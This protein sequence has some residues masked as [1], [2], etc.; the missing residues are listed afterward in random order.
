MGNSGPARASNCPPSP[1][2]LPA[3]EVASENGSGD[4]RPHRQMS[5]ATDI[6]VAAGLIDHGHVVLLAT[7]E[8]LC[9]AGQRHASLVVGTKPT[10]R[11]ERPCKFDCAG[12]G[13]LAVSGPLEGRNRPPV[14]DVRTCRHGNQGSVGLDKTGH[15]TTSGVVTRAVG[16][17]MRTFSVHRPSSCSGATRR[18]SVHG[19]QSRRHTFPSD[20]ADHLADTL[21][22]H[23]EAEQ[24]TGC[25]ARFAPGH[26]HVAA[27][28]HLTE[29][30]RPPPPEATASVCPASERSSEHRVPVPAA[31]DHPAPGC[32]SRSRIFTRDPVLPRS[33]SSHVSLAAYR[34]Q[35]RHIHTLGWSPRCTMRSG[36]LTDPTSMASRRGLLGA[37]PAPGGFPLIRLERSGTVFSIGALRRSRRAARSADRR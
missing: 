1:P 17:Q 2:F 9:A 33:S 28:A 10:L 22:A 19:H 14:G 36:S 6:P 7:P 30:L 12:D 20:N 13:Q 24:W 3:L 35:G 21:L 32:R 11:L 15:V 5:Q 26:V 25:G 29:A 31:V 16:G 23:F 27:R 8:R 18:E 4:W 34:A 37:G